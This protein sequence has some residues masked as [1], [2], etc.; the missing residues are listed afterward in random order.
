MGGGGGERLECY[1][2]KSRRT[3]MKA[4]G[5][6]SEASSVTRASVWEISRSRAAEEDLPR[7]TE[8]V[9]SVGVSLRKC[10]C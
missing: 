6:P 4:P 5:P 9:M 7:E 10:C 1:C 8:D 2:K 3:L